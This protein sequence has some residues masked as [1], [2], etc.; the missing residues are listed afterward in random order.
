MNN[1][2]PDRFESFILPEGHP[3]LIL[4]PDT[5]I[6]NSATIV[7]YKEDHTLGNLLKSQ[8]LKNSKVLFAGYKIPHPLE[9]DVVL[10]IQTVSNYSPHAALEQAIV[11]LREEIRLLQTEFQDQVTIYKDQ[12]RDTQQTN[13]GEY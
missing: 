1:N 8:L 5:K 4:T 9:Y 12:S 13:N 6:P 2:A 7:I 3:K 11:S 10:R